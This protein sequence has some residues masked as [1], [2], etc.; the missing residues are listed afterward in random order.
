VNIDFDP[1]KALSFEGDS[2]PYLC[3]RSARLHSLLQKGKESGLYPGCQLAHDGPEKNLE[4]K[5]LQFE[6]VLETVV[7]ELAP[8]KLVTYL[9]ELCG[10]FNHFY[11]NTKIIS[12]GK[13]NKFESEHYLYVVQKTLNVLIKGLHILGITAPEK[14]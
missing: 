7:N 5:I 13:E 6:K 11:N 8:Q 9:F 1:D 4:R 12:E 2:G 14:M 3:Y 10:E